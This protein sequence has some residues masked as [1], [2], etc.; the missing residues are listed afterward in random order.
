M[1]IMR[2]VIGCVFASLGQ[3]PQ[4]ALIGSEPL[5]RAMLSEKL[6]FDSEELSQQSCNTQCQEMQTDC[7]L[8][9]DQEAACI[10]RCRAEAADCTARCVREPAAPP[11]ES[12]TLT[13]DGLLDWSGWAVGMARWS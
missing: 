4:D 5:P 6:C 8:R 7:A 13:T 1:L 12:R 2:W 10:R 11:A 3:V 9:C